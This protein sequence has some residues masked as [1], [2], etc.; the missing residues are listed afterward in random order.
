MRNGGWERGP[1]HSWARSHWVRRNARGRIIQ[2]REAERWFTAMLYG[3]PLLAVVLGWVQFQVSG[4]LHW[5]LLPATVVA[6]LYA[7]YLISG[8]IFLRRFEAFIERASNET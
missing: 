1:R 3:T 7:A 2:E 8:V 4:W 6:G 5:A